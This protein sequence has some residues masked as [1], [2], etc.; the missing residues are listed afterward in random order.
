MHVNFIKVGSCL[1][2]AVL[3]LPNDVLPSCLVLWEN[4]SVLRLEECRS[5]QGSNCRVKAHQ[6]SSV[7][8]IYIRSQPLRRPTGEPVVIR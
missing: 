4:P 6:S 3:H 7:R 5:R 2:E 1:S 8:Q